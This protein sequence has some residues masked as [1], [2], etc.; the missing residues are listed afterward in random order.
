M[1]T[2]TDEPVDEPRIPDGPVRVEIPLRWSDMDAQG[3]VNNVRI[4]ELVQEARNQAFLLTPAAPM[5]DTGM[6]VVSQGVEFERSF[7]VDEEPLLVDVWCSTIGASRTIMEYRARHRGLEVARARTQFCP[8]DFEEE[9]PRRLTPLERATLTGMSGPAAQWRDLDLLDVS[10]AGEVVTVPIRWSDV[11]RYGH[12][13]NV[14]LTGYLQ[15]ARILATTSWSPGMRRAGDHLWVVVRQDVRYRRQLLPA[16]RSCRVH[17]ALSRLGTSSMTLAASIEAGAGTVVES[18]T[19]LVC[20]DRDSGLAT[21]ID[22]GTRTALAG[23][24]VS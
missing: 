13:N 24:L 8:F 3:H 4:W 10:G 20:V 23:H 9:R 17:T 5:L 15:E 19:V 6:V 21:P 18:L 22:E 11:D 14:S 16:A 12:V 7:V 1:T 2:R